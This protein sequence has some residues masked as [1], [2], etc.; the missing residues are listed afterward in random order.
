MKK[1]LNFKG[2][3]ISSVGFFGL[4]KSS[5]ALL[6]FL[7]ERYTGLSFTLRTDTKKAP[8]DMF[9]KVYSG[10]AATDSITEDLLFLS[11]SVRRD[12]PELQRCSENGVILS[13]DVEFFFENKR[14]PALAVTG[15]DGKSTTVT[16]ASLMLSRGKDDFPPSANIGL[17]AV[18]LLQREIRGTVCELSS[19]Q[20]MNFTPKTERALIT[21]VSENHLDWHTSFNEYVR[22]KE[23]VLTHSEKRIFNLDCP[24]NSALSE[25]Y[26][27]YAVFSRE[28]THEKMRQRVAANHYFSVENGYVCSSGMPLFPL[29]EIK[30]KGEHNLSNFLGAMA[31]SYE[32]ATT[33]KIIEVAQCFTGLAHRASLVGCYKG[34]SFYDSSIDST[35]TRTLATLSTLKA[36]T[37]LILG[38]RG[39]GLSYSPLSP[40]PKNVKAIILTGENRGEILKSLAKSPENFHRGR[41]MLSTPD[42]AE[43]VTLAIKEAKEGDAVL[44]SPAST[45]FDS[46]SDYKERGNAFSDIIKKHY[47]EG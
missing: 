15:S 35:P 2:K 46:F 21:N 10:A 5:L 19:F 20:L 8:S 13:S 27:A 25:K 6:S 34:I 11:P 12:R 40:L 23:N 42:F 47:A 7:S 29:K 16:L 30:L 26:P 1:I 17:P 31:L 22:A 38:G 44:L 32:I 45:S 9:T 33:E 43:A 39:K 3:R 24:Y 37:V 36:P 14:V 18:S 28:L 41:R 4:G